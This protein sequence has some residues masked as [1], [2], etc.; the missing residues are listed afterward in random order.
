MAEL[1]AR[2]SR[3]LRL[4]LYVLAAAALVP[5][6]WLAAKPWGVRDDDGLIALHLP[7]GAKD[8][9]GARAQFVAKWSDYHD[10]ALAF[11]ARA[12]DPD[13]ER[14]LERAITI[15]AG[16]PRPPFEFEWRLL[17]D[18]ALV[19]QGSGRESAAGAVL[20]EGRARKL[21][22]G[23]FKARAGTAYELRASF[24]AGMAKFLGASPALE[25]RMANTP[26][27]NRLRYFRRLDGASSLT[28]G[29]L[30]AAFLAAGLRLERKRTAGRER[31]NSL[32]TA[33]LYGEWASNG[34]RE[35]R[36]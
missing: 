26:R 5:S 32:A 21:L 22:F 8:L 10:V 16:A 9:P 28:L 11:P 33:M 15:R 30:G 29:L 27:V 17:Q 35:K 18:G 31:R 14:A 13:V 3:A 12:A 2:A 23:E 7:L 19:A 1:S 25:V 34:N 36:P 6:A 4:T 20:G 24:G